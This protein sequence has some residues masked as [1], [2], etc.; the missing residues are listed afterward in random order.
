[1]NLV[2]FLIAIATDPEKKDAY[3]KSPMSYV[4]GSDLSDADKE[5]IKSAKSTTDINAAIASDPRADTIEVTFVS[6]APGVFV[7]VRLKE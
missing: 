7:D 4:E 1:M 6:S 2:D 5:V 3:E